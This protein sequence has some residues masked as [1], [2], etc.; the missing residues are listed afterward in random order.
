MVNSFIF[1]YLSH[2]IGLIIVA[3]RPV[4]HT[5]LV[6]PTKR[7]HLIDENCAVST[8]GYTP[9]V[10]Q[11]NQALRSASLN[12]QRL[13]N[14]SPSPVFIANALSDHLASVCTSTR[15]LAVSTLIGGIEED[16]KA[17]L[18]VVNPHAKVEQC[19]AIA[20]GQQNSIINKALQSC[21]RKYVCFL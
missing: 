7:I 21:P 4:P 3:N 19:L 6:L 17:A 13:F 12:H 1:E 14:S 20:L 5:S 15:P 8:C 10:I 16:G 18:Y 9:D 2:C 11:V